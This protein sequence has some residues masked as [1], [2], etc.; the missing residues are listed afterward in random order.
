MENWNRNF[1]YLVLLFLSLI[2]LINYFVN[3]FNVFDHKILVF[4]GQPNERFTKINYLLENNKKY[5]SYILGSSRSGILNPVVF[6]TNREDEYYNLSVSSCTVYDIHK[7]VEYI[8]KNFDV[9]SL[10]LQIDP[11]IIFHSFKHLDSDYLRLHHPFLT[12]ESILNFKLKYLLAFYPK[13]IRDKIL[14]NYNKNSITRFNIENGTW[15]LTEPRTYV[16]PQSIKNNQIRN[17]Y[18]QENLTTL[19][20]LITDIQKAKINFKIIIPPL[21]HVSLNQLDLIS[22]LEFIQDLSQITPFLNFCFYNSFTLNDSNYYDL[23]HYKDYFGVKLQNIISKSD[24]YN[25]LCKHVDSNNSESHISFLEVNF[26]ENR[27]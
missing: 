10:I 18:R 20:L 25:D 24:I 19:K 23:T 13:S 7:M 16:S 14:T 22:Y 9:R 4:D 27:K 5:N 17:I 11:D 3:P 8:V 2:I 26:N 1:I 12:D 21:N 15:S 6:N